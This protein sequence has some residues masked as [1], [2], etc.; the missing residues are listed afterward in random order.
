MSR[1]LSRTLSLAFAAFLSLAIALASY[2]FLA[3]GLPLSFPDM[4]GHIDGAR[5]AFLAHIS[6]APVA[7]AIATFQ[8]MPGL[9]A[10]RPGLHRWMGRGYALAILIGGLGALG[11]LPTA[12]GGVAAQVGFG[13]LALCW[14]GST[15]IAV[16]HARARRFAE[17][18]RWM[19]RSFAFTFAAVTL[20]IQLPIL[21]GAFGLSY[22]A[23]IAIQAWLCWV[24]NLVVAE[25]VLARGKGKSPITRPVV[26]AMA[27]LYGIM[28]LWS[29]P[30]LS[31][32]AG[33]MKMFDLRPSG[34]DFETAN[35]IIAALGEQGR[36]FYLTV[37]HGLD[38]AFPALEA[39][40]FALY[41]FRLFS[42]RIASVLA[43]LAFVGAVFDELENAAV[44]VMLRAEVMTPQMVADASQ[45]TVLKSATVMLLLVILLAGFAYCRWQGRAQARAEKA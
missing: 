33:G 9:R 6:A 35:Q 3:L 4:G 17:H 24:P 19:I 45:W 30:H 11:M 31:A 23:A 43:A 26:V 36:S 10:R 44:A 38:T 5:L 20:R 18:R 8:L 40:A 14:M 34:Y 1:S 25:L 39:A 32:L 16:I 7:L 37:Q 12:N 27:A 2:R 22:V 42:I 41:F 21:I 28:L 15:A 29:L 13:L